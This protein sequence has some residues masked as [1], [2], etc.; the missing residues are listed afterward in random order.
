M[1]N[2]HVVVTRQP[3]FDESLT[4][5]GYEV[6]H[7]GT[8]SDADTRQ[9]LFDTISVGVSRLVGEGIL[10]CDIDR[11]TASSGVPVVLPVTSTVL[12]I[13]AS[14]PVDDE[15][16]G[17][18]EAL[19]GQGF[20][21]ALDHVSTPEIDPRLAP[22][23][24]LVKVER[25]AARR[26][27]I[28]QISALSPDAPPNFVV[29]DVETYEDLEQCSAAGFVYFQGTLLSKPQAISGKVPG[30]VGRGRL[31]M[32][33]ELASR[34]CGAEELEDAIRGEPGM[35][36]QLLQM[37]A[38]G[39]YHGVARE[40]TSVREALVLLGWQRVQAWLS[41]LLA[42]S[43]G[44][45]SEEEV[46]ELLVRAR[47]CELLAE[48]L[49][50]EHKELAF[51]AGMVAAFDRLLDVDIEDVLSQVTTDGALRSAVRKEDTPVGNIVADVSA[52]QEDGAGAGRSGV[53]EV[54]L[55]AASVAALGWALDVVRETGAGATQH[56]APSGRR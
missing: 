1:T 20:R 11:E 48:Q 42:T 44:L 47:M 6:L 45:A 30:V 14:L 34:E 56:A 52:C 17:G 55:H 49:C 26:E 3:I 39:S 22:L 53:S 54:A 21:L 32:A 43:T 15:L 51:T 4:V 10:F 2:E 23:I 9:L 38:V 13:D 41:F 12:E 16:V 36:Y 37:A 25:S 7:G 27:I 5:V 40:I 33:A 35:V 18:C 8:R 24:F 29:L 19:V 31:A 50:P 46:V 28:E